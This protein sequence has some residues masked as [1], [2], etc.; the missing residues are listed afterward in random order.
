MCIYSQDFFLGVVLQFRLSPPLLSLLSPPSL[1]A[2][3]GLSDCF[4]RPVPS[5]ASCSLFSLLVLFHP[6]KKLPLHVRFN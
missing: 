5:L 6:L 3:L 1:V 4:S 2:Y